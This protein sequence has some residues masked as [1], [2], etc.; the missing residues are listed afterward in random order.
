MG[1]ARTKQD[2][3]TDEGGK[4]RGA[5]TEKKA[6]RGR[7]KEKRPDGPITSQPQHNTNKHNIVL[8]YRNGKSPI[9]F[10]STMET[11]VQKK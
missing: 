4:K 10:E 11:N 5:S 3:G 6:K 9:K 2:K 1:T 7:K 8:F